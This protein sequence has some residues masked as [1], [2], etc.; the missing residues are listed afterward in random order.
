ME[1]DIVILGS[2]GF[3]G[4]YLTQQ[5]NTTGLNRNNIN[6]TDFNQV[7]SWLIKNTPNVVINCACNSN[8]NLYFDEKI[9]NQNLTIFNNFYSL[10]NYFGK[11]INLGSGAE[12]DRR[13][14]IDCVIEESLFHSFPVDHY[15][16]SKN[17]ISRLCY[18]T[19]NFYNLRLFGCFHSTETEF[20]LFKKILNF[21]EIHIIDRKFD[22]FYL[23]DLLTVIRYYIKESPQIKDINLVYKEKLTILEQSMKFV[24][25]NNLNVNI[26]SSLSFNNYTG[27]GYKL[28]TLDLNLKGLD[29]GFM[30]YCK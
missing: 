19:P 13:Y 27:S 16:K 2:N 28:E 6:L 17:I 14:S 1:N 22:Y 4:K 20:R 30:E 9:F 5:L 25:I 3:I 18:F 15:G 7:K 12:F 26:K 11:F 23:D 29:I 21:T 10:R 8:T 24:E